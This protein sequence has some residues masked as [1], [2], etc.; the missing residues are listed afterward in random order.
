[1]QI[2]A[3]LTSL[4]VERR[5]E[6]ITCVCDATQLNPYASGLRRVARRALGFSLFLTASESGCSQGRR[7]VYTH[8]TLALESRERVGRT[9]RPALLNTLLLAAV[10]VGAVKICRA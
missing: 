9:M 3:I 10:L 6:P 1:M 8:V 5:R 7:S 2:G 4:T